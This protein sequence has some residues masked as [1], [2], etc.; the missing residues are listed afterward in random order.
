MN[1][2]HS[3]PS[4]H[5]ACMGRPEENTADPEAQIGTEPNGAIPGL[6]QV[7]ADLRGRATW[8][9]HAEYSRRMWKARI[10]AG[11][12]LRPTGVGGLLAGAGRW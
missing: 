7:L 2:R 6:R 11:A 3:A 5:G 8:G 4:R 12:P 10:D 1:Y 9:L